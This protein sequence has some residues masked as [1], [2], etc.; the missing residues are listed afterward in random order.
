MRYMMETPKERRQYN[1]IVRF[2]WDDE[3]DYILSRLAKTKT[4]AEAA[5]IIGCAVRTLRYRAAEL[6][7]SF[8]KHG[9]ACHTSKLSNHEAELVR[10]LCSEG[11]LSQREVAE[12]MEISQATVSRIVNY[13]CYR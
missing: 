4:Q 6:G 1:C 11:G 3:K 13:E 5:K 2:C 10:E 12:K 7:I 8:Q 9:D